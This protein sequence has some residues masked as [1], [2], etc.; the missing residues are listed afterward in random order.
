MSFTAAGS[1]RQQRLPKVASAKRLPQEDFE[2][3][4]AGTTR[5]SKRILALRPSSAQWESQRTMPS[6]ARLTE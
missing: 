1:E 5:F 2:A 4:S 3:L 6:D